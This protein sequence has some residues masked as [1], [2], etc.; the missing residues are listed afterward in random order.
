MLRKIVY[1]VI[2]CLSPHIGAFASINYD[3]SLEAALGYSNNIYQAPGKEYIDYSLESTPTITPT[4]HAGFFIPLTLRLRGEQYIN[5]HN[6]LSA[7]LDSYADYHLG[8]KINNKNKTHNHLKVGTEFVLKRLSRR[9]DKLYLG[10][11][12]NIKNQSYF[13]RDTGSNRERTYSDLVEQ[14]SHSTTGYQLNYLST[15]TL[16]QFQLTAELGKRRYQDALITEN[17]NYQYHQLHASSIMK[18]SPLSRINVSYQYRSENYAKR[19]A[20][21]LSANQLATN[22]ELQYTHHT[23]EAGIE[24]RIDNKVITEIRL[25]R[26]TRSDN[27]Q[28][29]GNYSQQKIMLGLELRQDVLQHQL[30]G[31]FSTRSY[32][33]AFAYDNSEQ[34]IRTYNETSFGW[35]S[36]RQFSKKRSIWSKAEYHSVSSNDLRYDHNTLVI[37]IGG[38][39]NY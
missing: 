8:S 34:S 33:R 7:A 20:H 17:Q 18:L 28:D 10:L 37:M 35:L 36:E 4:Q 38:K 13:E 9:S 11:F 31:H 23:F 16:P 30:F 6:K 27:Y 25:S 12:H 14:Y 5:S 19:L 15:T 2:A 22:P 26:S 21:D 24:H 39:Y 3:L 29:Y 32:N 1:V